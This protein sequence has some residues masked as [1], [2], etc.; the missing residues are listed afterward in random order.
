[1]LN[2]AGTIDVGQLARLATTGDGAGEDVT[3][4]LALA[5]RRAGGDAWTAFRAQLGELL[6]QQPLPGSVVVLVNRLSG[7]A[8]GFGRS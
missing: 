3:V 7:V 8:P 2:E 1:L 6:G 5:C 4:L